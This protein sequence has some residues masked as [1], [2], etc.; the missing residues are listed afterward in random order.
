MSIR[1]YVDALAR[2]EKERKQLKEQSG[3]KLSEWGEPEVHVFTGIEALAFGAGVTL[4]KNKE[5]YFFNYDGVL[6]FQFNGA[7]KEK[8]LNETI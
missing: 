8:I 6:F 4:Q 2:N 1:N 5:T 3:V 7:E